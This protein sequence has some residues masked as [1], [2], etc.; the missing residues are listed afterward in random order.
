M[1][2]VLK[3]FKKRKRRKA[4]APIA[5]G[6]LLQSELTPAQLAMLLQGTEGAQPMIEELYAPP[7]YPEWNEAGSNQSAE[8]YHDLK[9]GLKKLLKTGLLSF[10]PG[11]GIATKLGLAAISRVGGAQEETRRTRIGP[12][13]GVVLPYEPNV[14]Y[15]A[16]RYRE[17]VDAFGVA[18][19][20][21]NFADRNP[22]LLK[23]FELIART[24]R[25][26]SL[27][28]FDEE[29]YQ[30]FHARDEDCNAC[31][32]AL[33]GFQGSIPRGKF[34][35]SQLLTGTVVDDLSGR[36][37]GEVNLKNMPFSVKLSDHNTP[38]RASIALAHELAHVGNKLYKL[39]LDHRAVHDLGVFYASEGFPLYS[40]LQRHIRATP[41]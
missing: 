26:G 16:R 38:A 18:T 17:M 30:R 1:L 41:S 3:I 31:D 15:A 36:V 2:K 32:L 24:A 39:G 4:A 5:E 29:P 37:H 23:F 21:S 35:R 12:T 40:A 10:I 14:A 8:V 20:F 27:D 22:R 33:G 11:A 34:Y 9:K 7:D 28:V 6:S 25:P 19:A 13:V